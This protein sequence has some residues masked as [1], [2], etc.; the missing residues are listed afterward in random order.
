MCV[1]VG[2]VEGGCVWVWEGWMCV[3]VAYWDMC[4]SFG[5]CPTE[6]CFC[7]ITKSVAVCEERSYITSWQVM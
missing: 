4:L 3:G 1:G 5:G 2:G 6:K 7:L